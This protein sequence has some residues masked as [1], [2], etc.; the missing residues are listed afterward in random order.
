MTIIELA[1]E[2]SSDIEACFDLSLDIN[3]HIVSAG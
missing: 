2:T 3:I 1:T